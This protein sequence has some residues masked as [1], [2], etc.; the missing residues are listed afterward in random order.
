MSG[1]ITANASP[2]LTVGVCDT[3]A[4]VLA[5]VSG[6]RKQPTSPPSA[7]MA[8]IAVPPAGYILDARLSVPGH[9]MPTDIPQSAQPA[10]D[11]AGI[12]TNAA[13]I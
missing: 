12:G 6:P 1:K 5:T 4:E 8:N 3:A 11:T 7:R 2:D 10:K 9:I 13:I